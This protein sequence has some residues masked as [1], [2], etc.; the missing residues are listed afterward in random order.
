MFSA[1]YINVHQRDLTATESADANELLFSILRR[2]S[3]ANYKKFLQCLLKTKQGHVV[4]IFAPDLVK[5]AGSVPLSE[6]HKSLLDAKYAMIIVCIIDTNNGLIAEL[7][8]ADC[9]TMRQQT[10]IE[11]ATTQTENIKRLVDVGPSEK[12]K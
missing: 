3:L 2:G 10:Y 12:R 6:E 8:S 7:F 11:S 4:S 1:G 5:D 9:I